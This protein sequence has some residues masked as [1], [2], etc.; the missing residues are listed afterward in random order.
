M[1]YVQSF[2]VKGLAG[3]PG[4]VA[5]ELNREVNV[6]WGL[7]GS[8]KTSLLKILSS[9]LSNDAATLA[10]VE[11]EWAKVAFWSHSREEV[12]ERSIERP[13]FELLSEPEFADRE[14]VSAEDW[15]EYQRAVGAKWTTRSPGRGKGIRKPG[16]FK[17]TFL[18]ISRVSASGSARRFG[19]SSQSGSRSSA[20]QAYDDASLAELFAGQVRS[21]W[22]AYNTSALFGIR[23]AQQ[24]ALAE[25]LA[26][27]F[28]GARYGSK[29]VNYEG[30]GSEA[31][32]LVVSF[33]KA[34]RITLKIGR[35]D[36]IDRF[37]EQA[38]LQ[39][40]VARIQAV[41]EEVEEALRPQRDFLDI[42]SSMYSGGKHLS[43]G[44][45]TGIIG[46]QLQVTSSDKRISLQSLSSGEKQ[47]LQLMLEVLA[48]GKSSVMIDEPE[49]SMHPDWQV[50][51]V[52][53]MQIVNPECQLILA[54][55]SPEVMAYLPQRYVFEL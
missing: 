25:I 10:G 46:Q 35:S 53:A 33:L 32:D 49:L 26:I 41:T 43:F 23:E 51:I 11:F 8:G 55:H 5:R 4:I 52:T 48:A 54:T 30:G 20:N 1:T 38:D 27:L 22:Q 3:R 28:G 2:E 36:F 6:I 37:E 16:G 24:K 39:H 18:P 47:L 44:D 15:E 40:V 42:V 29:S 17:H 14:Y 19:E 13:Q 50:R 31:Y 7:N 45:A 9:A 34:Q 21:K 12:I